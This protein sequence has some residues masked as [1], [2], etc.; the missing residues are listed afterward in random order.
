MEALFDLL[1]R[2]LAKIKTLTARK[3]RQRHLIRLGRRHDK[4]DILRRLLQSFQKRVKSLVGQHMYFVDDIDFLFAVRRSKA[5]FVPELADLVN[6]AVSRGVNFNDV[7]KSVLVDRLTISA[8][9]ARLAID[10]I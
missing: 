6:T 5:Y 3:H 10:G 8:V 1:R 4:K 9:I 7:G 2:Y